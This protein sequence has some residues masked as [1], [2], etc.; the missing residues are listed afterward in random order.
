MPCRY[1][2]SARNK[3]LSERPM[4]AAGLCSIYCG[5]KKRERPLLNPVRPPKRPIKK[6]RPKLQAEPSKKPNIFSPLRIRADLN[7]F[8]WTREP[9]WRTFGNFGVCVCFWQKKIPNSQK[10]TSVVN[11]D[12]FLPPPEKTHQTFRKFAV[13]APRS[14]KN[15][16]NRPAS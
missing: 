8:W 11:P 3:L 7:S 6:H 4:A 1:G 13:L 2:I 10:E 14:T 5:Q 9:T 15:H 12:F 16:L